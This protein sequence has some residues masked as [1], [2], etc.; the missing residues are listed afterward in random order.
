MANQSLLVAKT[1]I[2]NVRDSG[3]LTYKIDQDGILQVTAFAYDDSSNK[4]SLTISQERQ[5][6]GVEEM[7]RLTEQA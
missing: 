3:M 6:L 1:T 4:V 2:W 5:N 7:R